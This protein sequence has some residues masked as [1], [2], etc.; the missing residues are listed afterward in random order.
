MGEPENQTEIAEAISERAVSAAFPDGQTYRS[1][2][3]RSV[4]ELCGRFHLPGWELEAAALDAGVIPERYARNF[5]TFDPA[6]QARLL[7]SRVAVVGL[8]GLGG[9]VVEILAREGVGRLTLIDGDNFEA[10]NL[11]RQLFSLPEL[12]DTP[13]AAGAAHR[14]ARLNPSAEASVHPIFLTAANADAL[15]AGA[16]LVVD[17]LDNLPARFV[18]ESAAR[19]AGIPL[20]SAAI[21]GVAGHVTTVFPED[22][23]LRLIY[24]PPESAGKKGAEQSLGTLPHAITVLSALECS[25]AIKILRGGNPDLRNRL[26]L[27]DLA[28]TTFQVLDLA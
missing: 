26:L 14:V 11:N 17:C 21:G 19:R 12:L 1:L 16:D 7:R 20:I 15:L 13:K 24:G 6:D 10:S 18:L 27:M 4:Q 22:E 5:R 8:G 23:G 3:P 9:T 28:D 25:E 2:S